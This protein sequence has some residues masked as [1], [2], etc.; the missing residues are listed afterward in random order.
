MGTTRADRRCLVRWVVMTLTDQIVVGAAV[1]AILVSAAAVFYSRRALQVARRA[2]IAAQR[3][4]EFAAGE[5]QARR[6]MAKEHAI[7]WTL[8]RN[9][10]ATNDLVNIGDRTAYDVR[11]EV[12]AGMDTLGLPTESAEIPSGGTITVGV[13]RSRQASQGGII[14]VRWREAPDAPDREW[15]HPAV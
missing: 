13:A 5:Q 12:P 2:E 8:T 3:H 7:R 15:S 10:A 14:R 11:V 6:Q 9:G 4:A 1:L